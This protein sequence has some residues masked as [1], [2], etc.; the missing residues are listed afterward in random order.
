MELRSDD[1]IFLIEHDESQIVSTKLPSNG[2]VLRV[3]FYNLRKIK[4]DLRPSA[5]IVIKEVEVFWEKARIPTKETHHN[6]EKLLSLYQHWR[7]LQRSRKRRSELQKKREKEFV[8]SLND[9]FDIAYKDVLKLIKIEEDKLF[10]LNQRKKGR[11]GSMIGVD[12]NLT[13]KENRQA[14]RQHE[15]KFRMQRFQAMKE[16]EGIICL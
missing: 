12:I 13:R 16:R 5:A 6:I 4:L 7:M 2:Q 3:L 15:E 14:I 1:T 11:P 9:L 8:E 10:L